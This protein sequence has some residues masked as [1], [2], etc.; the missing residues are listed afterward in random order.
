MISSS[1]DYSSRFRADEGLNT[2]YLVLNTIIIIIMPMKRFMISGWAAVFIFCLQP[3]LLAQEVL[4]L[5]EAIE[6]AISNSPD[7]I[8]AELNMTISEE[9]LKAQQA[10]MKSSFSF[11]LVPFSYNQTRFFMDEFALWNTTQTFRSSGQLSVTQPVVATGGTIGLRNRLEYI[12]AS[13]EFSS[14]NNKGY[15]NNLFLDLNQPLFTFNRLKIQIDRLRLAL[16]NTTYDYAIRRMALERFVTVS[17]Y[18]VFQKQ[19]ALKIAEEEYENQKVS[20]EI[21][22]SKVEADLSPLEELYQAELNMETSKSN[23]QHAKVDLENTL[24]NFKQLIGLPLEDVFTVTTDIQY[25]QVPV[26]LTTAIEH[27]IQTRLELRQKDIS[28]QNSEYDLMMAKTINEFRG[29]VGLT[30]GLLGENRMLYDVYDTPTRTPQMA[31][32]LN[33]PI[34][35]WGERKSRIRIA[36]ANIRLQEIDKETTEKEIKLAIRQSYRKLENLILQIEIAEQTLKHARLTYEINLE[37]YKNGDLTSLDLGM[38]QRQ[39]SE[40]KMNLSNSLISYKLELLNMKI[41]SLWDFQN[42]TSF[43][44]EHLQNNLSQ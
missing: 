40:K 25:N 19:M 34:W 2:L 1:P 38:F 8:M 18:N 17:F 26:N 9:M 11:Q 41:Q 12:D 6:I 5:E 7:I 15:N 30:M 27:G 13:S 10:A 22:R 33:I 36:E 31:L 32:S 42:N 43:V 35:D 14:R 39:L 29:D 37:R 3:T 24:D 28:L 44:P 23:L 20:T 4:K 16:E 21:I